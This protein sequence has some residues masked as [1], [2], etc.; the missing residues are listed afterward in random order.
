M[1]R[2]IL[3]GMLGQKPLRY[4]LKQGSQ[5]V[6]RS[7]NCEIVL[8]DPA[9]SKQHAE[10]EL[11]GT[12][13]IV[14]DLGS[15]NGTFVNEKMV[16][17]DY[18]LSPRDN[19]RVGHLVLRVK[20]QEYSTITKLSPESTTTSSISTSIDEAKSMVGAT[21]KGGE[22]LI[23]AVHEFGQLLSRHMSVDQLYETQIDL[24]SKFIRADRIMLID[25]DVKGDDPIVLASRVI[26]QSPDTPIRISRTM[27]NEVLEHRRSFLTKDASID[28]RFRAQESIISSGVH[29]AMAAP[30]FDNDNILGV[31]YLDSRSPIVSYGTEE[32][33]LLTLLANMIAVKITNT[34]LE[35]AE[36]QRKALMKELELATRIQRNLLPRGVPDIPGYQIFAYQATCDEVG[37][38]LYDFRTCADGRWW[39]TLGDVTGHGIG[40]A[41]LMATTMAGLQILCESTVDPVVL[42]D[43][44]HRHVTRHVE[45]GQYVTM[46]L[47]LLDPGTGEI[48]YVNAGHPP[49][50]I[51]RSSDHGELKSTGI[52]VAMLPDFTWTQGSYTLQPGETV[53]VYSDGVT[54]APGPR[55]GLQYDDGRWQEFLSEAKDKSA[56]ALGQD[57]LEDIRLFQAG[58]AADDDLTLLIFKRV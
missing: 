44:L 6:G 13:L 42:V 17:G 52:P 3:S 23:G 8:P 41:L 55:D 18:V 43:R 49:P 2:F 1:A 45:S 31:V 14:R 38:D 39:M 36:E 56:E 15:R 4:E 21:A 30:L 33:Q 22:S 11:E 46:F 10:I 7:S 24:L 37:G 5:T 57:L 40:A 54:E 26:G 51:L 35:E 32:L 25:P 58:R 47:A 34:R 20:D 53:I 12:T 9:V 16:V 48:H 29:S 28:D 27:L 50:V 19:L